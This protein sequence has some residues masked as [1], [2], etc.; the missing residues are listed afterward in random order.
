[1]KSRAILAIDIAGR[2]SQ[3]LTKHFGGNEDEKKIYN[4]CFYYDDGVVLQLYR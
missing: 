1:M 4:Y 3:I 2:G